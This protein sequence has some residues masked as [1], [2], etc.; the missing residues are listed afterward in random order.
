M[1]CQVPPDLRLLPM[2]G[3][4]GRFLKEQVRP[5]LVVWW[6]LPTPVIQASGSLGQGG[7]F[8]DSLGIYSEFV[9]TEV[10]GSQAN[11]SSWSPPP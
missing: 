9:S 10:G 8:K 3:V 6:W 5:G 2:L 11:V 7:E 4:L 1:I